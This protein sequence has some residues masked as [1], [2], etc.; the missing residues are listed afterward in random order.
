[1][2]SPPSP[3]PLFPFKYFKE[4][5]KGESS[6]PTPILLYPV[7]VPLLGSSIKWYKSLI[8]EISINGRNSLR[9]GLH[10]LLSSTRLEEFQEGIGGG[11]G[12]GG[13][14]CAIVCSHKYT[15]LAAYRLIFVHD[16]SEI[17][18]VRP[19]QRP[20]LEPRLPARCTDRGVEGWR[21][22]GSSN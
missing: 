14:S 19:R 2:C 8:L 11:G 10:S 3:H 17:F 13:C 5:L 4:S 18:S 20:P 6:P 22:G 1:M 12:G 16:P 7:C 9:S 15:K 21:G